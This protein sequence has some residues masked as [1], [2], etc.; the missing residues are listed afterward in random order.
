MTSPEIL[1]I[2]IRRIF[3]HTGD[4]PDKIYVSDMIYQDLYN[5]LSTLKC[6]ANGF[7]QIKINGVL[8]DIKF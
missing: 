4:W 6:Y 7:Q 3:K 5:E 2:A 1:D 8:I